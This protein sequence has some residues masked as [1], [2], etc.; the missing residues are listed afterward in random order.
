VTTSLQA[1][2]QTR[3]RTIDGLSIRFAESEGRNEVL[4]MPHGSP[5]PSR[6]LLPGRVDSQLR[7]L[8]R[9]TQA[10]RDPLTVL[11][12]AVEAIW[13]IVEGA[14]S[15]GSLDGSRGGS[16]ALLA[17]RELVQRST[18]ALSAVIRRGVASG[19][20]RPRC[21]SWA[22]RRLPFA[23]VA[24]ACA[25]WVLGVST[26][27]SLRATTAV[28]ALWEVLRPKAATTTRSRGPRR[29]PTGADQSAMVDASA[30]RGVPPPK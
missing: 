22:I 8:E 23:I 25:H 30:L 3:F 2:I 4:H 16:S 10:D 6:S 19:T 11:G 18:C 20:F 15:E 28:A 17:R 14:G 1:S 13:R 27:P 21:P 5:S 7:S 12:K 24:G 29:P 9:S 26:G